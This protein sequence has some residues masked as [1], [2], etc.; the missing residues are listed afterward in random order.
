LPQTPPDSTP[1]LRERKK[2]QTRT[3]IQTHALELFAEQGYNATTVDQIIR[4]VDVSESTFFRYFPTKESLVLTDDLDPVILAA[5]AAQPAELGVMV[6]LR[7][8]FRSLFENLTEQQRAEQQER[9]AL[10]QGVPALRA[11]VFEQFSTT[12]DLLADAIAARA[13][14]ESNDFDVRTIAGAVIGA[15]MAVLAALAVDPA[16]D[17]AGLMDDAMAQLQNGLAL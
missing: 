2:A 12:M 15:S 9:M 17:Y 4:G 13:G 3:A 5:F 1:G 6:A 10:V 7:N 8:A 14:R 11:A 16:A